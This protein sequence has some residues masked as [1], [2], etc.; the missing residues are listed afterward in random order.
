MQGA[1]TLWRDFLTFC[2]AQEPDDMLAMDFILQRRLH[3]S[4]SLSTWHSQRDLQTLQ[5]L[6]VWYAKNTPRREMHYTPSK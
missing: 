1:E 4:G 2:G 6:L 3:S 5:N